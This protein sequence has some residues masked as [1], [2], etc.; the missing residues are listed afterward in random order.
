[1]RLPALFWSGI[2]SG[3]REQLRRRFL[4]ALHQADGKAAAPAALNEFNRRGQPIEKI[5]Q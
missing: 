3:L 2:G 4:P 1:M 5:A